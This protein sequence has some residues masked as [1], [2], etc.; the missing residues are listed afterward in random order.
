MVHLIFIAVLL[1]AL[2]ETAH[3]H[4]LWLERDGNGPRAPISANGS[5]TSAK[6][7]AV[8]STASKRRACFSAQATNR[9]R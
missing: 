9:C 6:K 1:I 2:S 5:T 7:P 4:F 8:C 3:A